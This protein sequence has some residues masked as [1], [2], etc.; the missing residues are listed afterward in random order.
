MRPLRDDVDALQRRLIAFLTLYRADA[1]GLSTDEQE[2]DPAR[3]AG[4][5][6]RVA[7]ALG[8]GRGLRV[9]VDV[10]RAPASGSST[11]TWSASP[12]RP[13]VDNAVRFAASTVRV[14]AETRR[15]DGADT[16]PR[17]RG[18]MTA[19]GPGGTPADGADA[20][21]STGLGHALSRMVARLHR[22]DGRAGEVA[23]VDLAAAGASRGARFEMRLP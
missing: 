12:S 13:A 4:Q 14:V 22:V 7:A 19:P 15:V 11:R 8:A 16:C 2:E 10:A 5:L 17:G 9:D 23:L 21:A 18:G 6:A 3:L 1:G 20:S